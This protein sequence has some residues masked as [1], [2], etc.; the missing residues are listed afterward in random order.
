MTEPSFIRSFSL[1]PAETAP[2]ALRPMDEEQRQYLWEI[3]HQGN[4]LSQI[5]FRAAANALKQNDERALVKLLARQFT[6]AAPQHP[7]EVAIT[8]EF[9]HVVR[10]RSFWP[11]ATNASVLRPLMRI[12]STA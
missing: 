4:I 6:G 5:G 3:E 8:N 11:G 12:R 9:V 7:K 2:A 10:R 1:A